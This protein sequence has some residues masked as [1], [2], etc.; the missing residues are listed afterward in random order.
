[1][2]KTLLLAALL[3]SMLITVAQWQVVTQNIGNGGTARTDI[4]VAP[5]GTIYIAYLSFSGSYYG[6]VK[7]YTGSNWETVGAG[8]IFELSSF[9]RFDLEI[10]SDGNLYIAYNDESSGER[11]MSVSKFNGS[12]WDI[13]GVQGF[14][15]GEIQ[16]PQLAFNNSN[17]PYVVYR[18]FANDHDATV[19]KYNGS[20]WEVV[21]EAGFTQGGAW[22]TS[23]TVDQNDIPFVSYMD[24]TTGQKISVDRFNDGQWE[25]VGDPGFSIGEAWESDIKTDNNNIPYVIYDDQGDN[26]NCYLKK[27][28]G[29]FWETIGGGSV[30]SNAG[31]DPGF[32]FDKEN[33]VYVVFQDYSVSQAPASVKK[34]VDG[35]W[36]YLGEAGFAGT[37]CQFPSIAIDDGGSI[38]IAY[39]EMYNGQTLTCAEY[40][41]EITEIS[42]IPSPI[43]AIYPNPSNGVFT[44]E[45]QNNLNLII[46]DITGRPIIEHRLINSTSVIDLSNQPEGVYFLRMGTETGIFSEKIIIQ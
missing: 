36:E 34:L 24:W 42:T 25:H 6:I 9:F 4:E 7:K 40:P 16:F 38:F 13:V 5:D 31:L 3:F 29:T 33:D 19:Q 22:C 30:S 8:P 12:T 45:N 43:V 26:D 23:I 27:W 41:Q 1:M 10:D 39:V 21:G 15:E 46:T 32:V 28:N 37:N 18:D 20:D 11:K 2:K 17:T 14:S 35:N 44:I